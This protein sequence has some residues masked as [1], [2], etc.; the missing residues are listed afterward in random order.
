MFAIKRR[1]VGVL[2]IVVAAV[3]V[4]FGATAFSRPA[5]AGAPDHFNFDLVPAA[6]IAACLHDAGGTAQIETHE[7]N[8]M[9]KVKVSGLVPDTAYDLFVIEFPNRPFGV[10]WY[11]SELNTN[12]DGKG[13]A[14]VQGIF[15]VETFSVSPGGPTTFAPTHQYH[16]GLWFDDPTD[17]STPD[18]SP[19]PPRRWSRRS[20]ASSTRVS[21]SSTRPTSPTTRVPSRTCN[22]RRNAE[23]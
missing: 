3:A 2:F 16:V 13:E 21:R 10:S 20:I 5:D 11:Q 9:M 1:T 17:L 23:A 7:V 14:K 4:A 8:Q 19:D 6:G 22:R 15:N 12:H 18:A